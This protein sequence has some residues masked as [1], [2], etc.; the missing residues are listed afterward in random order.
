ML[1]KGARLLREKLLTLER[2][3]KSLGV[4]RQAVHAW[5]TGA[6]RP[7][8][9]RMAQLERDFQIPMQSWTEPDPEAAH[10]SGEHPAV[11]SP[12]S[13]GTEAQG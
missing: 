5:V 6:A 7:T 12:P 11:G 2:I 9:E 3:A 4:S 8:P 10:E 13:T 1:T